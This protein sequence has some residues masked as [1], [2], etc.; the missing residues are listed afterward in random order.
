MDKKKILYFITKGNFG[1]AQRYVFDLATNLPKDEFE[2]LVVL[3]EGNV[4]EKKLTEAGVRV[5]KIE[6]LKR[7]ISILADI[8]SFFAFLKI[9]REENPDVVHLNSSKAGGLGALAVRLTNL[10]SLLNYSTT[11]SCIVF[12]GHGWAFNEKR[13]AL[14]KMILATLHYLTTLLSH[15][16]I[17]VS[18]KVADQIS[19]F[20]LVSKK[21]KLIYNGVG[22]IE[23]FEK[24]EARNTLGN[25]DGDLWIGTISEL[26]KNKGLD[27]LIKAFA[28]VSKA[29][30]NATLVIIGGGEEQKNLLALTRTLGLDAKVH[31][32]GFKENASRFL[33]AFD[34]FT[35]T[36]RTEAFPYVPLEAGLASLPVIASRVGGIPEVIEHKRNGLLVEARNIFQ[37][38]N[39]LRELLDNLS[40]RE[41]FGTLLKADVEE[42]FSLEKMVE[43]TI[44]LY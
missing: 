9:V 2:A 41:Q 5:V 44:A 21:I 11:Y 18:K 36:S 16:T 38:E 34:I 7:D 26:H 40:K 29:V 28:N 35:L 19:L 43:N 4:L 42:K 14:S 10:R 1:G 6:S 25:Y 31:F 24:K 17:A 30:P 8:Q 27:F 12:T 33:K 3:G 39:A 15:K 37:I 32:V 13:N 20:P 23:F 22:P